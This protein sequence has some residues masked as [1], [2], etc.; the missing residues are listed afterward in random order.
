MPRPWGTSVS[1][2]TAEKAFVTVASAAAQSKSPPPNTCSRAFVTVTLSLP[3]D[4]DRIAS[5]A[6]SA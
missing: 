4:D 3:S 1:T 5:R 6:A 2:G